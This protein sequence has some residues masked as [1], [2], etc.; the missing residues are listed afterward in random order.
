[1][2]PCME[3]IR[4]KEYD[5]LTFLPDKKNDVQIE[6]SEL[7]EKGDPIGESNNGYRWK[8]LLF[9]EHEEGGPT[10]I[11]DF[12]ATL[13]CPLEYASYLIPAGWFG[14][15]VKNTTTSS[16]LFDQMLDRVKSFA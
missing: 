5:V 2:L 11:D 12:E 1:M 14:M 3:P 6:A 9:K 15:I 10:N 4:G 13:G 8:I 7:T 16:E